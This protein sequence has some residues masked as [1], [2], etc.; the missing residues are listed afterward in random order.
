M[1]NRAAKFVSAVFAGFLA[2]ATLT[3]LSSSVANAADD[4]L[5]RPKDETPDGSHWYYRV[6]RVTKR[7]CWYLREEGEKLSRVAP[8]NSTQPGKPASQ[9]NET[10]ARQSIADA[11]AELPLPQMRVDRETNAFPGQTSAMAVNPASVEND[12]RANGW[13]ANPQ[14][15]VIASR[16]PDPSAVS[17][18]ASPEPTTVNSDATVPSHSAETPSPAVAPITLTAAD[19][20]SEKQ[21]GSI[22]MLLMVMIGALA[23]AGLMASA[24]FRFGRMRRANQRRRHGGRRAIWDSVDA[25]HA[26]PTAY[27][28][29]DASMRRVDIPRELHAADDPNGRVLE[30]LARLH[31]S[32]AN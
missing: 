11:R 22:R 30:M 26:S 12:R 20:S 27:P 9:Q 1:S 17:P 3:T 10:A 25:K 8:Q 32:T 24:I 2:S 28:R 4:C 7:H 23:V 14:L 15:S 21:S 19:S 29:S 5:S 16:W 18:P 6:D 31:R 13:D